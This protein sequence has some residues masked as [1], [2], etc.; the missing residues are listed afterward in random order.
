M[1]GHKHAKE[2]YWIERYV[3]NELR[4]GIISCLWVHVGTIL[5]VIEKRIIFERVIFQNLVH[6]SC[7]V[8]LVMHLQLDLPSNLELV[9]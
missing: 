8:G 7:N 2:I 5:H 6:N 9:K 1:I 3:V 4:K